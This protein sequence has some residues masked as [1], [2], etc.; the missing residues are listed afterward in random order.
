MVR[1]TSTSSSPLLLLLTAAAVSAQQNGDVAENFVCPETSGKF[2]DPEQCDLF[3]ICRNGVATVEFCP[4]GLLFDT[5][6]V[7]RCPSSS[8]SSASSSCSCSL[9][10]PT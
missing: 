4:E 7:N 2:A 1:T 10:P 9:T 5:T 3:Y 8:S 6:H